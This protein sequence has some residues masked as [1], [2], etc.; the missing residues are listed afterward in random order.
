LVAVELKE[1]G[2]TVDDRGLAAFRQKMRARGVHLAPEP[3]RT[4]AGVRK[5][6]RVLVRASKNWDFLR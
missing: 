2:E 4:G 3:D 6:R 5:A 1:A